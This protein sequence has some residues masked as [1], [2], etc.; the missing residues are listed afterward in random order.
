MKY[1]K[2]ACN[3]ITIL[4]SRKTNILDSL[5]LIPNL[6][7]LAIKDLM[8]A[9]DISFKNGADILRKAAGA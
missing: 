2:C 5:L 4:R 7:N 8:N 9:V 3:K 6:M 1:G